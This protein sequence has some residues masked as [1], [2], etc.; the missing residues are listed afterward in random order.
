[1]STSFPSIVAD[2]KLAIRRLA[3]APG[4]AAV[5]ISALALGIGANTA[6]FSIINRVVLHPLPYADADRLVQIWEDYIGDGTGQNTVSGG[7]AHSWEEQS[8]LLEG[9]AATNGVNANLS[10]GSQ[11]TRLNGLQVSSS[12]LHLLRTNPSLGRDFLPEEGRAGKSDVVILT[13]SA[14]QSYFGGRVDIVGQTI[15]LSKKPTTVIGILR[16]DARLT[17]AAD[18]LVPFAYGTPGWSTAFAGHN[19]FVVGRLKPSATLPALKSEMAVITDRIRSNFPDFK[20]KWG[21]TVVPLHE[22]VTGALRPQLVFLFGATVCVLLI[23]CFNVAGLLLARAISRER[24][25]AL[26]LALGATSFSIARQVLL[27]NVILSLAGGASGSVLAYWGVAAFERWR[28]PEFAPGMP[29]YIDVSV[30]GFALGVS[31]LAGLTSG[32]APAWRLAR[33]RFDQLRTGDRSSAKGTHTGM[34]GALIVGQVAI[35]LVLLAGAGLLLQSLIR[36]QAVPI[37]FQTNGVLAADLT[38]DSDSFRDPMKRTSYLEQIVQAVRTVPGVEAAGV[39]TYIPL[40]TWDTEY[41]SLDGSTIPPVVASVNF[42]TDGYYSAMRIP[43][44]KGRLLGTGDNEAN[45]APTILV[46]ADLASKFFPNQDPIGRHVSFWGR[47]Y[48]IVGVTDDVL[49]R[50]AGQQS[51]PE[52]YLPESRANG[53]DRSIVVRSTLPPLSLSKAVRAA[54]LSVAPDQ[55]VSNMRSYDQIMEQQAFTRRLMLGLT[56]LFAFVAVALAAIGLYGVMAFTVNSRM[57]ELGIR[58]ALGARRRGIFFLVISSGLKLTAAGVVLGLIGSYFLTHFVA[59]FLFNVAATAP[60]T[61][62][63]VTLSLLGIACAACFFPARRATK[64][65]PMIALRAE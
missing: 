64:V 6:I 25:M 22:Q 14:W 10:V 20:R 40:Q 51:N 19:L 65:D 61:V 1:M 18:Y 53:F 32:L 30:L 48:E 26:R 24:E 45:S 41:V 37:G 55:P 56:S 62:A 57:R 52:I 38:L 4:F 59:G 47:S 34:R 12:Y 58:T 3:K 49:I 28:P 39:A 29:V 2:L 60:S 17:V 33:S 21:V 15:Q 8:N 50:G 54:I 7:V 5:A 42:V 11:P 35:S 63:V 44:Q 13:Y 43:L 36:L 27:E 16:A 23:A 46:D 9:I 31:V